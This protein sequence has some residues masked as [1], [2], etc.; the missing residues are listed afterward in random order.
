[1]DIGATPLSSYP[2]SV[3]SF[4]GLSFFLAD[5]GTSGTEIWRSDGT[6]AGTFLLADVTGGSG[7]ASITNVTAAG[8]FLYFVSDDK[9]LWRT[10]GS[11][12]GTIRLRQINVS[13]SARF[14]SLTPAADGF[15][16]FLASDGTH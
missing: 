11:L 9:T 7:D 5:D 14:S 16:Y 6:N 13:A 12:N 2:N 10:D 15:I 4:N 3:T 1:K 8:K